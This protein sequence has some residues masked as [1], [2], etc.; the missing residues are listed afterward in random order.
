VRVLLDEMFPT[1]AAR[2]LREDLGRDAVHV[3]ELGLRGA[4]D[5]TIAAVARRED[6][7]VVAENVADFADEDDLVLVCVLKRNLPAG[8]AQARALAELIDRWL[9][10]NPRP[11]VGQHWPR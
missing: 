8:G 1:A 3:G 11:Y 6:R 2:H 10:D 4:D 7:A 9:A 5:A